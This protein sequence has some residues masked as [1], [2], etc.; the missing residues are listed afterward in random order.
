M[1]GVDKYCVSSGTRFGLV[2]RLALINRPKPEIKIEKVKLLAALAGLGVSSMD[3]PDVANIDFEDFDWVVVKENADAGAPWPAGTKRSEGIVLQ[4]RDIAIQF[5]E[6]AAVHSD[7]KWSTFLKEHQEYMVLRLKNKFD[8]MKRDDMRKKVRPYYVVG[9]PLFLLFASLIRPIEQ[10]MRL[11]YD[12]P[13]SH[14]AYKFS[15][16]QGGA[17]TLVRFLMG[18][19]ERHAGLEVFDWLDFGDDQLLALRIGRKVFVA[20]PDVTAMDMCLGMNWSKVLFAAYEKLYEG[21]LSKAWGRILELYATMMTQA[22]VSIQAGVTGLKKAGWHSGFSGITPSEMLALNYV[23]ETV[24]SGVVRMVKEDGEESVPLIEKYINET[25]ESMGI[26][27]KGGIKFEE[28][29][30]T[31]TGGPG[32]EAKANFSFLGYNVAKRNEGKGPETL[33]VYPAF[34][35][36]LYASL[37]YPKL[38]GSEQEMKKQ[39]VLK[40][41]CFGLWVAGG[42]LDPVMSR[43]LRI[44]YE[45]YQSEGIRMSSMEDMVGFELPWEEMSRAGDPDLPEEAPLRAYFAGLG[46]AKKFKDILSWG[47]VAAEP[48]PAEAAAAGGSV[49]VFQVGALGK[50]KSYVDR[51]PTRSNVDLKHSDTAA[52]GGPVKSSSSESKTHMTTPRGKPLGARPVIRGKSAQVVAAEFKAAREAK[53]KSVK[54]VPMNPPK[55]LNAKGKAAWADEG[56]GAGKG[57]AIKSK[58]DLKPSATPV[59][60]VNTTNPSPHPTDAKAHEARAEANAQLRKAK[61]NRGGGV[62]SGGVK[63]T[64]RGKGAAGDHLELAEEEEVDEVEEFQDVD[65]GDTDDEEPSSPRGKKREEDRDREDVDRELAEQLEREN[66]QLDEFG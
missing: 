10:N 8:L 23:F 16:F 26:F 56:S 2:E 7:E 55:K 51:K 9:T 6:A 17:K 21:K 62:G 34:S 41:R 13:V 24:K 15:W 42:Y 31:P 40:S 4:S 46:K 38:M 65:S 22:V 43:C 1:D 63:K 32:G 20:S 5:L 18:K 33:E 12:D 48:T 53:E 58:G 19:L 25:G 30:W 49:D 66:A 52:A 11:F 35:E 60:A 44:R 47:V 36:K 64:S 39:G 14:S 28:L 61:A 59:A 27:F 3:V 57:V 45:K 37:V 54:T 29:K 50:S